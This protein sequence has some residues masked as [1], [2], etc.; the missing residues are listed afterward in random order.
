MNKNAIV[1]HDGTFQKLG[2][3]N[4]PVLNHSF[5]YGSGVFEGIRCYK[6][7]DGPA[8]FRLKDHVS[9]LFY[10]AKVM[11]MKV[12]YT[13]KQITDAIVATVKKNKLTSCYI[14]PIF[15]YGEMMG[16]L[17]NTGVHIAIAVW[18]W[19]KY[20]DQEQTRV[21]IAEVRRIPP[22]AGDNK[23][24][25]SGPY[26]NSILAGLEARKHKADEALL[27]DTKG[28]IA[29]GPG[30]NIFFVKGK[31][32]YTPKPESILPGITRKTVMELASV[33]GLSARECNISPKK[34]HIYRESF[35]TGTAV[36]VHP[37]SAIDT[38]TFKSNDEGSVARRMRGLY[39]EI[40][41]G[42]IPRYK[43]WLTYAR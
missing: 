37:I 21:H 16:V 26:Y 34:L 25:I 31:T 22:S 24:K 32:L 29:E 38:V 30:E 27:L 40:V 41:C 28:N 7:P 33:L 3:V 23:A 2:T 18:P 36:E 12:P 8:I 9:R 6:T 10:S 4:V 14:R 39:M 1:W 13:Q 15:Y 43:K 17:P 5:H 19:G 42:N 35:F 11:G 20:I